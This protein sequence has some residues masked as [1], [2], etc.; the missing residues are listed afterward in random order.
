MRTC[1]KPTRRSYSG[2]E[3]GPGP[4]LGLGLE[5]LCSAGF[6]KAVALPAFATLSPGFSHSADK[7]LVTCSNIEP[8]YD[9]RGVEYN[10]IFWFTARGPS[11]N[12]GSITVHLHHIT[13]VYCPVYCYTVSRDHSPINSLG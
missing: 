12:S 3:E 2:G 9:Y 7:H 10:R 1:Y 8:S 6:Y 13:L 11:N 4:H 5:W